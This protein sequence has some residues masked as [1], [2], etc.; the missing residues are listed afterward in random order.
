MPEYDAFE[1]AQRLIEE[2]IQE[3]NYAISFTHGVTGIDCLRIYGQETEIKI[4][5]QD[6]DGNIIKEVTIYAAKVNAAWNKYLIASG[7]VLSIKDKNGKPIAKQPTRLARTVEGH[8]K[9]FF[10]WITTEYTAQYKLIAEKDEIEWLETV[11]RFV[12]YRKI[13]ETKYIIRL[14]KGKRHGFA[15]PSIGDRLEKIYRFKYELP[16]VARLIHHKLEKH[17]DREAYQW[18]K[19][20]AKEIV[21][22]IFGL[23]RADRLELIPPT[24][25][26][27]KYF[28][29]ELSQYI[30]KGNAELLEKYKP[31]SEDDNT[32]DQDER[33]SA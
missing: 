26:L 22:E 32:D 8:M 4:I 25:I 1:E 18:E 30:D 6:D 10:T 20:L 15:D 7:E 27:E 9:R 19:E 21:A 12:V 14:L 11:I 31:K 16:E 2:E 29:G 5:K 3:E 23:L 17:K 13:M 28:A 33:K 24:E